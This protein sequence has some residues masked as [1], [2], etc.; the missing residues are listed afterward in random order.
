M[1]NSVFD[2]LAGPSAGTDNGV[3][4]NGYSNNSPMNTMVANS[5]GRSTGDTAFR[6][7]IGDTTG[8]AMGTHIGNHQGLASNVQSEYNRASMTQA[9]L[10]MSMVDATRGY[11]QGSGHA[12][13]ESMF[14][15]ANTSMHHMDQTFD[16]ASSAL[17][18]QPM[19]HQ[20]ANAY[21]TSS[22]YANSATEN[23]K[24]QQIQ[25]VQ[26]VT[27]RTN[28]DLIKDIQEKKSV[29]LSNSQKSITNNDNNKA[30]LET[31]AVKSEKP[32]EK[33]DAEDIVALS[34][35]QEHSSS[36]NSNKE[37]DEELDEQ[38]TPKPIEHSSGA[39]ALR[40]MELPKT[41]DTQQKI[42][43]KSPKEALKLKLLK[44]D[45]DELASTIELTQKEMD[46]AESFERKAIALSKLEILKD[47]VKRRLG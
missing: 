24:T 21:D 10:N 6:D 41:L 1:Q 17:Y 33:E 11:G 29:S 34:P 40:P 35:G 42:K 19:H 39:V 15:T 16:S 18:Q 23:V 9:Q 43:T 28:P 13:A 38:G 8:G 3:Y 2:N 25:S 30:T 14:E 31:A 36:N 27:T 22:L 32:K 44:M 26:V 12:S 20:E 46:A 4:D 5:M 37:E 7:M 45:T 47:E